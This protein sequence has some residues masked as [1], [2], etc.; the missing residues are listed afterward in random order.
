MTYLLAVKAFERG[1]LSIAG[2]R[3]MRFD[4]VV[5]DELQVWGKSRVLELGVLSRVHNPQCQTGKA[6]QRHQ[7]DQRDLR[8]K[9]LQPSGSMRV[10]FLHVEDEGRAQWKVVVQL[11][12]GG[13]RGTRKNLCHLPRGAQEDDN[14]SDLVSLITPDISV[15]EVQQQEVATR[16]K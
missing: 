8:A 5:I 4:E 11:D 16:N 12:E 10:D 2:F 6:D 3:I 14:G 13:A 9:L 7:S 1:L 15:L